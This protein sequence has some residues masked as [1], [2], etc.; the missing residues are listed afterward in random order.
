MTKEE[1]FEFI[2]ENPVF[3]L[4]TC[5]GNNPRVRG[6]RVYRANENGIIF[7]TS[8]GKDLH[9]QL[10]LNPSV[11]LCFY[12]E[13]DGIQLRVRGKIQLIE[14]AKFKAE[15]VRKNPAMESLI[16][17]QGQNRLA[18]YRL[19]EG[20]VRVWKIDSDYIPRVMSNVEIDSIWMAMNMGV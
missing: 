13:E 8:T 3:F 4:A 9:K 12:S 2:N 15:I 5:E 19:T 17:G 18:T 20:K 11:E 16:M 6:M 10:M 1:I 14:D 7:N